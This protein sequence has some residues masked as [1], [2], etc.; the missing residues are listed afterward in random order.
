MGNLLS[1]NWYI[2]KFLLA[3][4]KSSYKSWCNIQREAVYMRLCLMNILI[5]GR[6]RSSDELMHCRRDLEDFIIIQNWNEILNMWHD[7]IQ[8]Y[9]A[10][11]FL[12]YR[13]WCIVCKRRIQ[14]VPNEAFIYISSCWW[15][16]SNI[17]GGR[18]ATQS[19]SWRYLFKAQHQLEES[20][21]DQLT[22]QFQIRV[23]SLTLLVW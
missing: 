15:S 7:F 22:A 11:N 14:F 17:S 1:L 10:I 8:I 13:P 4:M 20:G 23:S 3:K 2:I 5:S 19:T 21:R 16:W 6:A 18:K 12:I 9:E